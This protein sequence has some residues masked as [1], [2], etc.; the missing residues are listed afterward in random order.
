[1]EQYH[2]MAEVGIL[3]DGDPVELLEGRLFRKIT[4]NRRHSYVTQELLELLRGQLPQGWF[5]E[6]QEPI[7]LASGEPEPD[8]TLLRG[9][10]QQ[11][12]ARKPS[13]SDVH[14]VVEVSESTLSEDLNTK[15]RSYAAASIAHYWIVNLIDNR[16]EWYAEPS[17]GVPESASYR[18]Q[19][20]YP[21]GSTLVFPLDGNELRVV[22]DEKLI[23]AE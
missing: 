2:Q 17:G 8:L 11:F 6:T 18:Q 4:K 3:K 19:V 9:T 15:R 12:R 23:P 13:A 22:V 1:V 7:V 10:R 16:I 5:L 21:L 14:L 20:N